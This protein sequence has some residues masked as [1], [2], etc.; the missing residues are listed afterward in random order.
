ERLRTLV[1]GADTVARMG[2]DE[3]AIVQPA[4]SGPSDAATLAQRIVSIV[5]EPYDISGVQ[6][7]IGTT[8]GIS[9]AGTP[10]CKPENELRNADIALYRA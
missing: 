2:G 10:G 5:G 4:I 1:R 7:V 3:F 9:I 8:I 6:V